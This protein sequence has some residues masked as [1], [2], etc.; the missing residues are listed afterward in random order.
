M[1]VKENRTAKFS[2]SQ[3]TNRRMKNVLL[4]EVSDMIS[5]LQIHTNDFW[6]LE[7]DTFVYTTVIMAMF[8]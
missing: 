1:A 2:C 8:A 7:R 6:R 4:A 3:K 5:M